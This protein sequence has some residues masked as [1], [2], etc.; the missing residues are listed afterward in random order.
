MA[1]FG[2]I[3]IG[4]GL[5]IMLSGFVVTRSTKNM[6]QNS[7]NQYVSE[8]ERRKKDSSDEMYIRFVTGSMRF[9]YFLG[10]LCI[11]VGF[12]VGIYSGQQ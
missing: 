2:V 4:T 9:L 8:E 1:I 10:I 11:V 5:L 7:M 6:M 3:L 12:V